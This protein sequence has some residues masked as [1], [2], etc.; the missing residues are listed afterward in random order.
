MRDTRATVVKASFGEELPA[1]GGAKNSGSSNVK[2]IR[3]AAQ[4]THK[5][6]WRI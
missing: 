2:L 3:P 1:Y 4:I 5:Y 6:L